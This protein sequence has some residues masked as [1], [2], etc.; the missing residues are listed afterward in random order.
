MTKEAD[1]AGVEPFKQCTCCPVNW[2][3]RDDFLSDP[4]VELIGY[5]AH[6]EDLKAGLLLF[7]HSCKTTMAIDVAAFC[8]LYDG[9][10]FKER[11]TGQPSCQGYC[12]RRDE[13]RPCPNRCECAFVRAILQIVQ[14]WKKRQAA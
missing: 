13:L 7:N 6:F 1:A 12:L 4:D 2:R 14:N 11:H 9:P 3:T 5:Q 8:D 10:V